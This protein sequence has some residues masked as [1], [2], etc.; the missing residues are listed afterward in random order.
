V[1]TRLDLKESLEFASAGKV[2]AIVKAE[3]L[4]NIN[5]IFQRMREGRIEGRIVVDYHMRPS[6]HP[7]APVVERDLV[8]V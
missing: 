2:K 6:Q 7:Q 4:E 5:D 8:A 3:P 1:G